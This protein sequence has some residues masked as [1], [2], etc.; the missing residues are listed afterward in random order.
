MIGAI[1]GDIIGS[2]YEFDRG[3]KTKDFTL[4]SRRSHF[5]DDSVMT[6]AVAD[7]LMKSMGKN[8]E[9]V[10]AELVS[11]MRTWGAKYPNAGYGFRFITWLFCSDPKPYKSYGNGSA[12][13]VSSAGWLYDTLEE[14]RHYARLTASVSHNH[15][16]GIKG[17]EATASAIFMARK[18]E[19]KEVIKQ[20]II[21][22]FGYDLS[23]TCDEIRPGYYHVETCQQT[24]PEALTAF[25]E[26]E[27]FEDVIRTAV[28]LGGDCD[29]LTCIAGSIAE[30]FYGI[31]E[32]L[33]VKTIKR[34]PDDFKE[35]IERFEKYR[36][37][38]TSVNV[39]GLEGNEKIEAAIDAFVDE[40]S[41]ENINQILGSIMYRRKEGG[42]LLATIKPV[43]NADEVIVLSSNVKLG[44]TF[45]I[46][47]DVD[48]ELERFED[49]NG[50]CWLGAY[51]TY[52]EYED[53]EEESILAS[54]TMKS[55]FDACVQMED[56]TG[57]FLNPEGEHY[58]MIPKEIVEKF[59]CYD[60]REDTLE[61][62]LK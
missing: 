3:N 8:D 27:D 22:E 48:Y 5:T 30:A 62:D 4:F 35:V 34:I 13:R 9:E 54:C 39:N 18:G 41:Q 24:V 53:A 43:E 45:S 1:L 26:G 12:M 44:N 50:D 20:Y 47:R 40:Q 61:C 29:T 60:V 42:H 19:K 25:L 7:A 11:T 52:K 51:T 33:V 57:V 32:E 15:K 28:S 56:I 10:K 59:F 21:N 46:R 58:M 37:E 16:E 36:K 2:P 14:T 38:E 49:E 31:P 17:A 6:I 55:F 23:R